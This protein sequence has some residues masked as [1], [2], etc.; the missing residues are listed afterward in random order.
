MQNNFHF[1]HIYQGCPYFGH[2]CMYEYMYVCVYIYI[3]IYTYV[4]VCVCVYISFLFIFIS[5]VI[6]YSNIFLV[7]RAETLQLLK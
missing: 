2:D 6:Y 3:H 1:D 5:V 4:Y 7:A